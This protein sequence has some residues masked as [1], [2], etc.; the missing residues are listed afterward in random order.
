MLESAPAA[1][2]APDHAPAAGGDAEAS[3]SGTEPEAVATGDAAHGPDPA[4]Q[5]P[6]LRAQPEASPDTD[7]SGSKHEDPADDPGPEC[8]SAP[9]PTDAPADQLPEA[10]PAEQR[11][12]PCVNSLDLDPEVADQ[13]RLMRRLNPEIS[14][15]DLLDQILAEGG[16]ADAKP[17]GK[18]PS[19]W[20][21]K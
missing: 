21:R 15:G 16:E 9:E 11:P 4:D 2:Q 18:K 17:A 7:P 13:L 3:S 6:A 19:W 5:D 8:S 10:R 12:A 1:D 14:D 20:S